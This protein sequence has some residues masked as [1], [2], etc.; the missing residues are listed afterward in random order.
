M[1]ESDGI[2]ALIVAVGAYLL[3]KSMSNAGYVVDGDSGDILN[4]LVAEGHSI[5][6]YLTGSSDPFANVGDSVYNAA[7][8]ATN[9]VETD[10]ASAD[11]LGFIDDPASWSADLTSRAD[12]L[13]F[14]ADPAMQLES[15]FTDD[16]GDDDDSLWDWY[17]GEDDDDSPLDTPGETALEGD[18]PQ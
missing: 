8:T 13:S 17:G 5:G 7:Q 18:L 14:I 12:P 3:Y 2:L 9:S 10:L 11:P 15:A 6:G 1:K 16:L 4:T